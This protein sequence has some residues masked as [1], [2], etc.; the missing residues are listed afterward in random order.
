MCVIVS[1]VLSVSLEPIDGNVL[2]SIT[3]GVI[4]HVSELSAASQSLCFSL[5][6]FYAGML[7]DGRPEES[8]DG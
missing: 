6:Y 4:E 1:I 3:S 8:L 7:S 2:E 5:M